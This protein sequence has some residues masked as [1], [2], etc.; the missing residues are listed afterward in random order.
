[1]NLIILTLIPNSNRLSIEFQ[2]QGKSLTEDPFD[3]TQHSTTV[4]GD[5]LNGLIATRSSK[6]V[7]RGHSIKATLPELSFE[8]AQWEFQ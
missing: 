4:M 6:R 2:I 1:V 7:D 3:T 8:V 5:L